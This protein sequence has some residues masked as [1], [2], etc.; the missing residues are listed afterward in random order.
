MICL[1]GLFVWTRESN[2]FGWRSYLGDLYGSGDVPIYAAA[3]RA[4]DLAGLPP[5]VLSVGAIDGFRDED[6][7]YA[8]RLN[9]AGV[10][11]ELHVY[12]GLPH[13]YSRAVD[14][15]AVKLAVVNREDWLGRQLATGTP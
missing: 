8:V 2:E 9:Q 4:T 15:G 14:A 6:V 3:S 11:C 12:A 7:D 1:D 13:G 10:P 5:A